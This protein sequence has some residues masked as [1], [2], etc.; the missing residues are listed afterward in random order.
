MGQKELRLWHQGDQNL[1]AGLA[2]SSHVT[3]DEKLG[4]K[5][6]FARFE[7]RDSI[8]SWE[9]FRH[10]IFYSLYGIIILS[11]APDGVS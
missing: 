11:R 10:P 2:L 1:D 8:D 3:L 7:I 6:S 5:Y 4:W 9:V